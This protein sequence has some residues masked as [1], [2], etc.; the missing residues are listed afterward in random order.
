MLYSDSRGVGNRIG[1]Y[2]I[3]LARRDMKYFINLPDSDLTYLLEYTEH[4]ND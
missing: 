4:F 3:D 1:S 2:L